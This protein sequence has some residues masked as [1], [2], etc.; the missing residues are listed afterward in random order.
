MFSVSHQSEMKPPQDIYNFFPAMNRIY[1]KT[2]QKYG[3]DGDSVA[4][5]AVVDAQPYG[6]TRIPSKIECVNHVHKRFGTALRKASKESRLGGR[7]RGRLTA[8]KCTRLQNYFRGAV[9]NYLDSED[10][11]RTAIWATL[12]HCISTDENPHHTRCPDGEDSWCFFKKAMAKKEQPGSH[13]DHCG[14]FLSKN[15]C[16]GVV[17]PIHPL[18]QCCPAQEDHTWKDSK[19]Q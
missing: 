9:L 2:W 13:D 19:H 16:T 1:D 14:T 5:T 10:D 15:V 18:Q 4:Y 8:D 7:G 3:S 12:F 17:A 11:M 6:P